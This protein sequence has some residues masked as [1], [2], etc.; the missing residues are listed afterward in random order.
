[1]SAA[2]LSA[3]I[4]GPVAEF[5]L[6]PY[7][8]SP[9]GVATWSWLIGTGRARGIALVFVLFSLLGLVLTAAVFFTRTYRRLN[10]SY[11]AG[12]VNIDVVPSPDPAP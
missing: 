3:F 11:L 9:E 10:E 8:Q 12:D 1:M 2:P 5:W 7:A 4:I 6:I